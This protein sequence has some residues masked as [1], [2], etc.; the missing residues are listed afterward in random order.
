MINLDKIEI[1]SNE[2]KDCKKILMALGDENRQH[3]ILKMIQMRKCNGV[4][5]NDIKES[6]NLSRPAISHH[7]KILKE[8]G[9][10]NVRREGTKNYY[11]FDADI[12]TMNKLIDMLNHAKELMLE[13]PNRKEI[14]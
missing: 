2:F 3:L 9:L 4:R 13:L 11:F 8:A 5:V 6:S 7:I 14:I 1:I 12:K 10:I